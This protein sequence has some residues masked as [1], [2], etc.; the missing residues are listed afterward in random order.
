MKSARCWDI[1]DVCCQILV[2]TLA[3]ITA[4]L[5]P[6]HHKTIVIII[7]MIQ[8]TIKWNVWWASFNPVSTG[9]FQCFY[10]GGRGTPPLNGFKVSPKIFLPPP[11]PLD[12]ISRHVGDQFLNFGQFNW[13]ILEFFCVCLGCIFTQPHVIWKLKEAYTVQAARWGLRPP[14]LFISTTLSDNP[15]VIAEVNKK[16]YDG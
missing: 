12:L 13:I 6:H 2:T 1:G 8:I 16:L 15:Y 11:E 14:E 7:V 10:A 5:H 9:P 3:S 4:V